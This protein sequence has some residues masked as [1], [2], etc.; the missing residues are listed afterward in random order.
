MKIAV[1]FSEA[2]L[3]LLNQ[4]P[5]LP[6]DYI[7]APT[8]SLPGSLIQFRKGIL[9]RKLLPHLAQP[10]VLS[11][12]HLDPNQ[13]FN[14]DLITEI[15]CHTNPPY[16]S[17]HLEAK[18]EYF[19]ELIQYQHMP[20]PL[21]ETEVSVRTL[22]TLQLI[23]SKLSLPIVLENFP[24]YAWGIHYRIVSEPDFILWVCQNSDCDFLLDI[25]HARCSAW[26][27]HV[28]IVDYLKQ[29]PLN[30]LRE[31]H[32]AGTWLR[33]EGLVDAHTVLE[34][35]DYELLSFVLEQYEPEIITLEYGG[36]ANEI[37][38]HKGKRYPIDRNNPE[39]LRTMIYR[40]SQM[41]H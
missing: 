21:V 33:P 41:I 30:R 26:H 31:I 19:P 35:E 1:N 18:A 3:D 20:H 39:E 29:L 16:L 2:L 4:E 37:V 24:Y 9:H 28:N 27:L 12:N 32:L 10:G 6:I 11:L 36:M 5:E 7:K 25:A 17:T 13:R 15:I 23:K 8:M 38:D 14:Q 40:V 34:E 22:E